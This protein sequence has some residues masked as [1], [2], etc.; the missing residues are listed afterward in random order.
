MAKVRKCKYAEVY[1][2]LSAKLHQKKEELRKPENRRLREKCN[3]LNETINELRCIYLNKSFTDKALKKRYLLLSHAYNEN[4]EVPVDT[5][6]NSWE[7]VRN[8]L[9]KTK[10]FW[11]NVIKDQKC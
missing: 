9:L 7:L 2:K 3:H 8:E 10:L 6:G 1:A 11:L 5:K 4:S